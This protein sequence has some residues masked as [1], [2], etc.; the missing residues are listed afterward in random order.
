MSF[1][2]TVATVQTYKANVEQ[3]LQQMDTRLLGAVDTHSGYVGKAAK[4]V[5]QVGQV[6]MRKRT[7]RHG[8]VVPVNTPHDARWIHPEDYD[9]AD[10]VDDQDKLRMLID[11]TGI[12]SQNFKSAAMRQLDDLIIN[13]HF[14]TSFTGENGTTGITWAAF[15]A[16][17]PLH[18][19]A[20]GGTGLTVAKLRAARKA[21][22]AAEVPD[23]EPLFMALTAEEE[24]DLLNE[25]Q[26]VNTDYNERAVLAEGKVKSFL[27]FNF[28]HSERLLLSGADRRVPAWAKSGIH[29]G[30][31]QDV[32]TTVDR[33]PSK[34]KTWQV[35]S[36]LTANATRTQEKKVVEVIC[37]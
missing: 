14:G 7:V 21:F 24:D 34:G 11:P 28:L 36:C 6:A 18:S 32:Y 3:L 22:R 5:E 8:D 27:G 1:Q 35:Y 9:I 2:V 33:L 30:M 13:A 10:Y 19:I 12:Y 26:I 37:A 23:E 29:C 25:I 20:A 16:A 15:I 4:I 17:N 31:W